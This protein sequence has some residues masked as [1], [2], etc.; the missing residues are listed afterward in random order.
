MNE[1]VLV[2]V[3][4]VP[5]VDNLESFSN[6]SALFDTFNIMQTNVNVLLQINCIFKQT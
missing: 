6:D 2:I 4:R 1:N 3:N 5:N